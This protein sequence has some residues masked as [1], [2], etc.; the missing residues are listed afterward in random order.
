METQFIVPFSDLDGDVYDTGSSI[1][2]LLLPNDST[3]RDGLYV[4]PNG[5][6][7]AIPIKCGNFIGVYT[8]D[9]AFRDL[10]TKKD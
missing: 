8:F 5:L 7:T 1:T 2:P 9:H 3:R 6:F 4:S 10:P